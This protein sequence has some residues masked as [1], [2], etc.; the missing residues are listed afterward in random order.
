MKPKFVSAG[1]LVGEES[2]SATLASGLDLPLSSM[3]P[4]H[5]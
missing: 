2:A 5:E 4:P 1:A 3:H